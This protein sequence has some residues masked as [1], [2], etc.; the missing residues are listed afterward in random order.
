MPLSMSCSICSATSSN[1]AHA[2]G[3]GDLEADVAG[4]EAAR[5]A[6]RRVTRATRSARGNSRA[7]RLTFTRTPASPAFLPPRRRLE[8]LIEDPVL[9]LED[10][11]AALRGPDE[12]GERLL[13]LLRL[14][15]AQERLH[16]LDPEV[17]GRSRSAGRGG[18][19]GPPT[20]RLLQVADGRAL[21]RRRR[22]G[23]AA[24]AVRDGPSFEPSLP[25]YGVARAVSSEDDAQGGRMSG[26]TA[27]TV[28]RA[29]G[30]M[31]G[32]GAVVTEPH[33]LARYE[34]GWRYGS[35]TALAV[36]RP[37]EHGG[38]RARPRLRLRAAAS[39]SCPRART[40][41]WWARPRPT[42][43]ARCWC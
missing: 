37:G 31:L 3:L 17:A 29:L 36:V 5:P 10:H 14:A 28:V 27:P 23:A 21:A 40:P 13:L 34:K 8:G 30:E 24:L 20:T 12:V 6:S 38:G 26:R 7:E 19:G 43:P 2:A 33:E 41:A 16:P 39:A 25:V 35:G 15:P 11:R 18:G 32:E 9:E 1:S 4:V 42:R 22:R